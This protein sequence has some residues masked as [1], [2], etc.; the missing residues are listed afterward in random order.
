MNSI[1]KMISSQRPPRPKITKRKAT[2]ALRPRVLSNVGVALIW[3]KA[4]RR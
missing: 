3:V 1:E 2:N 4:F